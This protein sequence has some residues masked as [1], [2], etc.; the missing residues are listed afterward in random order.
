MQKLIPDCVNV[1]SVTVTKKDEEID[2][3]AEDMRVVILVHE[4][5]GKKFLWPVLRQKPSADNTEGILGEWK[6]FMFTAL[7]ILRCQSNAS[8]HLLFQKEKR[9]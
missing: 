1:S 3:A 7:H 4:N 9:K 8:G 2:V 5:Q 6:K